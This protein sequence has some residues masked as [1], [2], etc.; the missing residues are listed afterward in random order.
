MGD[1][2]AGLEGLSMTDRVAA[3]VKNF[4]EQQ[5]WSNGQWLGAP[6]QRAEDA[7]EGAFFDEEA[8][9]AHC[10]G[11]DDW[12]SCV[13]S[14]GLTRPLDILTRSH[15]LGQ[16]H[17]GTSPPVP[18]EEL[19]GF[20]HRLQIGVNDPFD[21]DDPDY[22]AIQ[23]PANY[24][25][26]LAVT[27]GI[28]DNDMRTSGI[29]G[30]RGVRGSDPERMTHT[31][32]GEDAIDEDG[33]LLPPLGRDMWRDGWELG[34]GFQLGQGTPENQSF[35]IYYYCSRGEQTSRGP[36]LE[37]DEI[38]AEQRE[39]KWR[40]FFAQEVSPRLRCTDEERERVFEGI[41]EWLEW[42]GDWW[43]RELVEMTEYPAW[44]EDQ[45]REAEA[46]YGQ[47]AQVNSEDENEFGGCACGMCLSAA[48]TCTSALK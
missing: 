1:I 19:R 30:I 45:V 10:L 29:C 15:D 12:T 4:E 7:A 20:L 46:L 42:Y 34:A 22:A 39:W 17:A 13:T 31:E 48:P 24:V 25:S 35:M 28:Y 40:I 5:V 47:D 38:K 33:C 3:A 2:T 32:M 18:A 43:A 6:V 41:I 44:R 21:K 23:L 14:L 26:L 16:H 8:A 37:G 9:L 27:D 11:F 36:T